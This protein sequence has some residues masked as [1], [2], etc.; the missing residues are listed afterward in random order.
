M[1]NKLEE[2]V[3]SIAVLDTETNGILETDEIIE[4]SISF[5]ESLNDSIDNIMNYTNRYKPQKEV[6]A[7]ASSVHF[8]TN[9]DLESCGTYDSELPTIDALMGS[10][11]YYVGHNVQFDRRMMRQCED[12]Y[13][14]EPSQYLYKDNWICTLRLAKKLHAEDS[15]YDNMTLSYLWF[16]LGCYKGHRKVEA[17]SA[18][19]DV[20]MCYSVLIKLVEECIS[21]GIIDPNNDIGSQIIQYCNTP[22]IYEKVTFGKHK[23]MNFADLPMDYMTWMITSSDILNTDKEDCDMDLVA[24]FQYEYNRRTAG[25]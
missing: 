3:N 16:K 22:I 24:T 13:R 1:T 6:P 10:R 23:G 12:K 18:R 21:L 2:F 17:H 14:S 20:F 4:F 15:D 25:I 7:I 8:I 11:Q 5:P 19:D 9:E